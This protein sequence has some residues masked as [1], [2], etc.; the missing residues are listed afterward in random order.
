MDDG[1]PQLVH[2]ARVMKPE[3]FHSIYVQVE[4]K[5]YM[6]HESEI[7]MLGNQEGN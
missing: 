2:K 3:K 6:W 4:T 7:A 5:I 1:E